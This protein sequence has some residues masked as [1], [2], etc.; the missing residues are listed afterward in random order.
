MKDGSKIIVSSWEDAG[1]EMTY[2][3][4]EKNDQD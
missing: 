2:V 4:G 3:K 1:G